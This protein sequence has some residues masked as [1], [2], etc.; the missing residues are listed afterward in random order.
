MALLSTIPED[1]QEEI[2]RY[3]LVNFCRNNPY[4]PLSGKEILS[5]L[6]ESRVCYDKGEGEE[7]DKVLDEIGMKY[8]L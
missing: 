3:L 7:L 8:G 6:A 2:Q 5:E 4:K 1:Y